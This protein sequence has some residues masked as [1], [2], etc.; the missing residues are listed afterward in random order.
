M[1]LAET[2]EAIEKLT[3]TAH[4]SNLQYHIMFNDQAASQ[5]TRRKKKLDDGRLFG[6][7]E[8]VW[9]RWGWRMS[10]ENRNARA[11]GVV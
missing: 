9:R 3:L 5:L 11:Q 1:F 6:R 4:F 7:G 2:A 8:V 10:S